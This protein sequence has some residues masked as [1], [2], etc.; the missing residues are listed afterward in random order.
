M[1]TAKA[2]GLHNIHS[3]AQSRLASREV[4]LNGARGGVRSIARRPLSFQHFYSFAERGHDP[5]QFLHQ[6]HRSDDNRFLVGR[7]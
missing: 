5:R 7:G 1:E 2:V 3:R 6:L 4:A